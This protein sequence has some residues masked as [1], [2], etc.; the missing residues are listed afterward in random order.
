[1]EGVGLGVRAVKGWL[2][3]SRMPRR[4]GVLGVWPA[5]AR[6]PTQREGM[7]AAV[8]AEGVN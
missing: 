4:E 1:M 7:Q 6:G 3:Q 5:D 2:A 8:V